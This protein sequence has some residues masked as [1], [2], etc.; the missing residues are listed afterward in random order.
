MFIVIT[1]EVFNFFKD[2]LSLN[3]GLIIDSVFGISGAHLSLRKKRAMG[4]K[5]NCVTVIFA[6]V[7]II[8]LVDLKKHIEQN[9]RVTFVIKRN[10]SKK[11]LDY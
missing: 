9:L 11:M 10:Q 4:T 3:K 2:L 5:V 1:Q 7:G 6:G 8:G